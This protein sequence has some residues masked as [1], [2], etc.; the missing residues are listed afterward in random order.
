MRHITFEAALRVGGQ[1]VG[2]R[3]VRSAASPQTEFSNTGNNVDFCPTVQQVSNTGNVVNQQG[4]VQYRSEAD[5]LDFTLPQVHSAYLEVSLRAGYGIYRTSTA[6][7]SI[8]LSER[9]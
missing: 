9:I 4:V 1:K 2:S 8:S 6:T 3:N 5:D 7:A